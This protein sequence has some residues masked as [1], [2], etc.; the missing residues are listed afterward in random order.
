MCRASCRLTFGN[1]WGIYGLWIGLNAGMVSMVLGLI[2]YAILRIDWDDVV[3]IA[4]ASARK[5]GENNT[6][7]NRIK[8]LKIDLGKEHEFAEEEKSLLA[9]Q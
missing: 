4:A 2:V 8:N 6:E 5:T 1:G 7:I 3:R 9:G